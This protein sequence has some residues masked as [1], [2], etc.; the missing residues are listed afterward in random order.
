MCS[1][2]VINDKST[3]ATGGNVQIMCVEIFVFANG[4]ALA[5]VRVSQKCD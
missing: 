5:R 3:A 4:F 1:A 2:K